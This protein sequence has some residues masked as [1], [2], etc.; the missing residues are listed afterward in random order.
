MAPICGGV[1][2]AKEPDE[3]VISIFES[4]RPELESKLGGG[5]LSAAKPVSYKSQLV[6]GVNYFIKIDLGNDK[7]AHV[8]A[9]R[10]FAGETSLRAVQPDKALLDE[11]EYFDIQG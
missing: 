8:R 1:S 6:N 7:Y 4:I 11:I 9:Y 2:E 10:S 5:S 3:T